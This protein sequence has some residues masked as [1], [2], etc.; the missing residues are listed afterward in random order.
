MHRLY[1][2]RSDRDG[3]D[4]NVPKHAS[5]IGPFTACNAPFKEE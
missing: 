5:E 1:S 4:R 3:D 2:P